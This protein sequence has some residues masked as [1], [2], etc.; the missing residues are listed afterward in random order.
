MQVPEDVLVKKV[1]STDTGKKFKAYC[2]KKWKSM[3]WANS[4]GD[5]AMLPF[6][7]G[8][9]DKFGLKSGNNEFFK[10]VKT[11]ADN[12]DKIEQQFK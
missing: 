11:V 6:M 2:L 9:I 1:L 4:D 3:F 12:M 5:Y 7:L 8:N 10:K